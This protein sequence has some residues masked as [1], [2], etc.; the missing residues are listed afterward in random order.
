MRIQEASSTFNS[1]LEKRAPSRWLH[2]GPT[3]RSMSAIRINVEEA[4][5]GGEDIVRDVSLLR[6]NYSAAATA[7]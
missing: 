3:P 6:D 2:E 5:N 4:S 1:N 7:Q